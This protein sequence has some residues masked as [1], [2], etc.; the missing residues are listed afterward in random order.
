MS[1][2][3]ISNIKGNVL[4]IGSVYDKIE[5]LRE[6]VDKDN[7]DLILLNGNICFPSDDISS[8]KERIDIVNEIIS[9]KVIYISGRKDF[10]SIN[11][12]NEEF[13]TSWVLSNP[14]VVFLH[15]KN[16]SK[17]IVMDGGIHPNMNLKEIQ[18]SVE[19]SFV[20]KINGIPWHKY[21]NGRFGYI[22]SNKPEE[23]DV[24]YYGYSAQ[25]GTEYD[26]NKT[27]AVEANKFGIKNSITYEWQ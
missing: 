2:R 7:Y 25:I 15:F 16:G 5:K 18:N 9:H 20:S 22:I 27:F 17:I 19:I 4:I 13:I 10:E 26:S 8:I 14:N 6:K 24:N 12:L 23:N 21:Y 3:I 11:S 1:H